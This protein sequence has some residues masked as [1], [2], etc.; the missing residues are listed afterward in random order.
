MELL[1]ELQI[2]SIL[3][4]VSECE[5]F[6][7]FYSQLKTTTLS[8]KRCIIRLLIRVTVIEALLFTV[9]HRAALTLK[10]IQDR[11]ENQ[12]VCHAAWPKT[13]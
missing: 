10:F 1:K 8:W 9:V 6:K 11:L 13:L 4:A 7:I 12:Q 2:S 3:V 5:I